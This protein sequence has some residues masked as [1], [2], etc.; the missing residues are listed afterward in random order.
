MYQGLEM[1]ASFAAV[2][3]WIKSLTNH[4]VAHLCSFA[5]IC[6]VVILSLKTW[7]WV[8]NEVLAGLFW[9]KAPSVS[10]TEL[11]IYNERQHRREKKCDQRK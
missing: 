4:T 11:N 6:L 1:K 5:S 7:K 2:G 3:R 10:R 8:E 9:V